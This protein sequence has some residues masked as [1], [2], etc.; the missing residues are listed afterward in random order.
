M[1]VENIRIQPAPAPDRVR[2]SADVVYESQPGI[3]EEYWY[4]VDRN[5]AQGLSTWGSP[6]LAALLPLAMTIR[7]RL[8][9]SMPGDPHL[10]RQAH[11]IMRIWADWYPGLPTVPIEAD[12]QAPSGAGGNRT[13]A[14]FSG[15]VDSF[16]TALRSHKSRSKPQDG[17][18]D[19][20]ITIW[21]FDISLENP[22]AFEQVRRALARAASDLGKDFVSVSTN[23][24]TRRWAVTDW[25]K[26]SHGAA[27]ASVALVLEPLYRKILVPSSMTHHRLK[28]WGSHPL[29]DPLFSTSNLRI[30]YDGIAYDRVMKLQALV[31]CDVAMRTLRVCWHSETG[32]KCGR[33][34]KCY[35]NMLILYLLGSLDR[36]KTFDVQ[37]FNVSRVRYLYIDRTHL[38]PIAVGRLAMDCGRRDIAWALTCG[39]YRSRAVDCVIAL[40]ARLKGV[41]G[42]RLL[43]EPLRRAALAR[44]IV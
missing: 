8:Y 14:F 44:T 15:G 40:S 42:L 24:R 9:L 34:E 41:R 20:L 30:V 1:R 19:D 26:L 5:L 4:E 33:C 29:I 38:W 21:G 3:K 36:C 23:L 28:P 25:S 27:L 11:E 7:E 17:V 32:S 37:A 6:W 10:L 22:T 43:A 39:R 12:A 35:R 16:F 13:G 2:L 18:I 31:D